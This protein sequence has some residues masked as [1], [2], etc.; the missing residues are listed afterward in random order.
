MTYWLGGGG[1]TQWWTSISSRRGV[2]I[3]L[4]MLPAKETSIT[5]GH[6]GLWTIQLFTFYIVTVITI[7]HYADDLPQLHRNCEQFGF[8]INSKVPWV[9]PTFHPKKKIIIEHQVICDM[10]YIR[11]EI[12]QGSQLP[13]KQSHCQTW[14]THWMQD[15]LA[16]IITTKQCLHVG[17]HMVEVKE[18]EVWWPLQRGYL[19]RWTFCTPL[20]SSIW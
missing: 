19:Q 9:W 11:Q 8:C 4:G 18:P 14:I 12:N 20:A 6:L 10:N 5:S 17:L 3:L 1:V 16:N 13:I 2:A 7:T 15:G